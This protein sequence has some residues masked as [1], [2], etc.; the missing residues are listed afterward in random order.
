MGLSWKR[1]D[2]CDENS[3]SKEMKLEMGCWVHFLAPFLTAINKSKSLLKEALLFYTLFFLNFRCT[4]SGIYFHTYY[5]FRFLNLHRN[6]SELF[7][8]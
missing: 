3:L 4:M 6:S 7:P 5:R 2:L 1:K 8:C